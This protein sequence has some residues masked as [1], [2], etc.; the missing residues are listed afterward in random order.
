LGS[1]DG[2]TLTLNLVSVD[3]A[4]PWRGKDKSVQWLGRHLLSG[5]KQARLN[6]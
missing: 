1:G 6:L 4:G 3:T 5:Q 2:Y